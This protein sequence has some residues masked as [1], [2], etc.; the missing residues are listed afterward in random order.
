[1]SDEPSRLA[2]RMTAALRERARTGTAK[3]LATKHIGATSTATR[4]CAWGPW[5]AVN[6]VAS[7]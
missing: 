2:E 3:T 1:M 5:F 6:A 4:T 7:R